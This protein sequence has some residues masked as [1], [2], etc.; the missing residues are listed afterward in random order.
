MENRKLFD[1]NRLKRSLK[2][3][4][5]GGNRT[6]KLLCRSGFPLYYMLRNLGWLNLEGWWASKSVRAKKVM[7]IRMLGQRAS[8]FQ[9]VINWKQIRQEAPSP[10]LDSKDNA[11][12]PD[13]CNKCGLCCEVASGMADFPVPEAVPAG[14]GEF[15]G[16]G[17]GKGHRF[18]PFLWEDN[19]TS[20]GLCSIYS[21]RSN[22][23]RLFGIE[24]CEFFWK[25]SEPGELSN[26]RKILKI[27]RW[28]ISYRNL[29]P[30][31][32]RPP[33]PVK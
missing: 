32:P 24:E 30:I 6:V 11:V 16:N 10:V 27:G 4:G 9:E 7:A 31:S 20:G 14:W 26:G 23:C 19:A 15:F 28:L 33:S 21:L 3:K 22:P 25:S 1:S 8:V 5:D 18:C 17:L 29:R 12:V 2:T 13:Y